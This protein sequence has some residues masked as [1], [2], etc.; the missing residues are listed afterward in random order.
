[1]DL[2]LDD[3]HGIPKFAQ[4]FTRL[5]ENPDDWQAEIINE[6][7]RQASYVGDFE[8]KLVMN[9]LD[10]ERRYAMG[11][12]ELTSRTSTN[13][14]DDTTKAGVQG[15]KR[16][17]IPVI[18]KDGKMFPLDV[19]VSDGK[20]QPLTQARLMKAMFRPQIFETISKRPGDQ[21][22][23]NVLYPPYRSGGFGLGGN[24][25]VGQQE[26]AKMSSA[27]TLMHEIL[28]TIKT[29]DIQRVENALNDDPTLRGVIMG[30]PATLPFMQ[31][32][33]EPV[34]KA[35]SADMWKMAFQA[36]PP[37]VVQV[38]KCEGGFLVK[39]ANPKAL[40]PEENKIDRPTASEVVGEDIVRQV[41]RDGTVT[42]NTE[43]TVRD[44]LADAKIGVAR[45]FGEYKV[46]TKDGT[47]A[48]GWVFPSCTD[49]DGTNL[50][51]SLF[52]NGSESAM[53]ENIA[54]SFVGKGT[55]LIDEKPSGH[56]FFYF[57]R[58]G[59][60]V[61]LVPMEVRG[62]A[63][64]TEGEKT[65]VV[66]TTMGQEAK[67]RMVPGILKIVGMGN[68]T[69]GIPSDCGWMPMKNMTQLAEDANDYV[70]TAEALKVPMQ[71]ELMYDGSSYSMRGLGMKKMASVLPTGFI[72]ADQAVYNLAIL[73][74]EPSAAQEKLAEARKLSRWV[75]ID[76]VRPVTLAVERA[77]MAKTAADKFV[78]AIPE[79]KRLMLK[80]AAT[81][82]DP[83]SVDK[84]LSIGFLNPENIGT[85][86][87][88]LPEFE[89][90]LKKLSELLVA[91]RLGLST[92]DT[93]ALERV[94]K[95]LDKVIVG[96]RE[97]SQHP[98]A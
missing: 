95:H 17:L 29:A 1:M 89:D 27:H 50:P 62:E 25:R 40:A 55:N 60:A 77:Q 46:K 59:G 14:R 42:V 71:V 75:E 11:S 93:G 83:M 65:Y 28:P 15:V 64:D 79:V 10:P 18:V 98:Q 33:T 34:E 73:G 72:N 22:M 23:M 6:L 35:G 81:L 56:G 47:E 86:I 3:I 91:S 5:S 66:H 12:I 44:S 87:S 16:V 51:I 8:P 70:K 82:D 49:L 88:Y 21:D 37:K 9:E 20:S 38:Q 43:P 19:F 31:Y 69:Y 7:Y 52:S 68:N 58:Q 74:M 80:E 48:L 45:E 85:F 63:Q 2:F 26:T 92:V 30:N 41:E 13:P 84:V 67:I 94:V 97:L 57:S 24:S 36:I 61:A 53:Q 76:G 78:Q 90:T 32:L 96:L 39:T 54:G 4:A